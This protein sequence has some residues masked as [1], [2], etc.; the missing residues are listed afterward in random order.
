MFEIGVFEK[1]N[2][3]VFFPNVGKKF[4]QRWELSPILGKFFPAFF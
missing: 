1:E 3:H 4:F 2:I